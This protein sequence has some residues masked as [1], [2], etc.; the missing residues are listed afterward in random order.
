MI[1]DRIA[2]ATLRLYKKNKEVFYGNQMSYNKT[3]NMYK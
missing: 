1:S 3:F 2:E